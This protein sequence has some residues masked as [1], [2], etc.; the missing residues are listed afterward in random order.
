MNDQPSG[1]EMDELL[2]RL[3]RAAAA[4]RPSARSMSRTLSALGLGATTLGVAASA[5]ATGAGPAGTLTLAVI[6]KWAGLGLAS[7]VVVAGV[8]HGVARLP[9]SPAT[10]SPVA[11]VSAPPELAP[12]SPKIVPS[13]SPSP[14]DSALPASVVRP[15]SAKSAGPEVAVRAPLA[16]ELVLV[17]RGRTL[18]QRSEPQAAL[19]ALD[20][21]E[22]VFAEPR[23]VPEVLYLRME[24]FERLGMRPQATAVAQ[25]LAR[26]FPRSPH[27][28]RAR[29]VLSARP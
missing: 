1:P 16:A 20:P 13:A 27:A 3:I 22:R 26:D 7:G 2:S 29:D 19:S 14:V 11:Q 10:P 12:P 17:D 8:A 28:A 6:G 18:L 15:P 23:L 24:A 21:Y 4:E 5:G 25:Q 9:S